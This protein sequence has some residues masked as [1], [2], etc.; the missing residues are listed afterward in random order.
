LGSLV[1]DGYPDPPERGLQVTLN[2]VS[3]GYFR[4]MGIPLRRG[5][6]FTEQDPPGSS[7]GIV[8]N[9]AA[10]REYFP[11][12][13]AL[14][15]RL[16]RRPA[17]GREALSLTV[18]GIV[19]DS[20]YESVDRP[21][22]PMAYFLTVHPV[23]GQVMPEQWIVVRTAGDPIARLPELQSV[24]RSIDPHMALL[25]PVRMAERVARATELQRTMAIAV[26]VFGLFALVLAAVG[27]YGV[28]AQVVHERTREIGVRVALGARRWQIVLMVA[29]SAG[30][31]LASGMV[32]GGAVALGVGRLV[33]SLLFEV[34]PA[35]PLTFFVVAG[36]LAA[37]GTA[38]AVVPARRAASVD[39][40]VSL[41]A[42]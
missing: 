28:L 41:R 35:D 13:D 15:Q 12:R 23:M 2:V 5:R 42:E 3:P 19:A 4:A 14:G 31:M 9:E 17:A 20:R 38:A 1:P 16:T 18:I 10:A 26:T 8:L 32:V 36:V 37:V 27:L 7:A 33:T 21:I 34:T 40:S 39:P 22:R 29:R 11:G 25:E 24:V 6:V 30:V